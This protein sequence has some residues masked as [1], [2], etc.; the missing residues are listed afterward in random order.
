VLPFVSLS[1][2][3][4]F[5]LGLAQASTFVRQTR[6]AGALPSCANICKHP[7]TDFLRSASNSIRITFQ[8][9]RDIVVFLFSII[10]DI[11]LSLK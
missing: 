5:Q 9:K 4:E 7:K 3:S 6:C 2:L 8:N 11:P 10:C 1:L